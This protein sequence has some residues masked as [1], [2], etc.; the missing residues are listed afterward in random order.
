MTEENI[1]VYTDLNDII[2]SKVIKIFN[3]F[4]KTNKAKKVISDIA[5]PN[6][7]AVWCSFDCFVIDLLDRV[8]RIDFLV[9]F[10][11]EVYYDKISAPIE[12]LLEDDETIES[13]VKQYW[14][15]EDLKGN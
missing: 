2:K 6:D 4:L 14:M 13:A 8:V 15:K 1:R 5:D 11:G 12:L 10:L 9:D 3:G 7:P